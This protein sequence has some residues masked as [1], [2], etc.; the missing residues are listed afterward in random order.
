MGDCKEVEKVEKEVLLTSQM[1]VAF[2]SYFG[3]SV[4]KDW[5]FTENKIDQMMLDADIKTEIDKRK[6]GVNSRSITVNGKDDNIKEMLQNQFNDLNTRSIID[7]IIDSQF[8][9]YSVQEIMYNEDLNMKHLQ[10]MPRL[11][12][13]QQWNNELKCYQWVLS[14]GSGIVGINSGKKIPTLKYLIPIN[15]PTPEYPHGRSE[16]EPLYKWWEI[17]NNALDYANKIV[18]K[19]GGVITWFL[20]NSDSSEDEVA[21]MAASMK[22]LAS[23]NTIGIPMKPGGMSQG[24]NHDFGFIPMEKITNDL[25]MNLIKFCEKQ[26]AEYLTGSSISSNIGESGSY[27]SANAGL[28]LLDDVIDSDAKYCENWL[29]VLIY[30]QSVIHGFDYKEY[31][32]ELVPVENPAARVDLNGKKLENA[33]KAKELGFVPKKSI[34]ADLLGIDESDLEE[35]D[36]TNTNSFTREFAKKKS[37]DD[38]KEH[39]KKL[40]ESIEEATE[41]K[42]RKWTKQIAD[43]Y[44]EAFEKAKTVEDVQNLQINWLNSSLDE[45]LTVY[46]MLGVYT[47]ARPQELEFAEEIYTV[48]ELLELPF[49]E[50]ISY[51]VSKVPRLFEE[52]DDYTKASIERTF[53]VKQSTDKVVTEKM[54]TSLSKN[55]AEGGTLR[56]WK[57]DIKAHLKKAGISENGYY[58]ENVYRTNVQSSY[59]AGRFEQQQLTKD[60]FEYWLYNAIEDDRTSEICSNLDGS[61]FKADDPIWNTIYPL[62]HFG[63][64]SVVTVLTEDMLYEYNIDPNDNNPVE[65]AKGVKLVNE[66]KFAGN[67]VIQNQNFENQARSA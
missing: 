49:D 38:L 24:M 56:E 28:E 16:L 51:F 45:D 30:Y 65:I 48:S 54:F 64:R 46:R 60:V 6:R 2:N 29:N 34:I 55:I 58:L 25:H 14:Y 62:N 17:K 3:N 10:E 22:A 4:S 23:G 27:S 5:N 47:Q 33:V 15:R 42:A 18:E 1:E 12:Y 37:I 31:T 66:G 40:D 19:Y 52:I 7:V 21:T 59:N 43:I 39:E 67:P 53:W 36:I 44:A 8:T 20:Y 41:E 57:K 26:I 63:C 50:A 61:V 9:A 35:L 32:V 13:R 11:W